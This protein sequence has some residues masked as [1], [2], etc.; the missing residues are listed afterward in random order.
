MMFEHDLSYLHWINLLANIKTIS[1]FQII[2]SNLRSLHCPLLNLIR[3][4]L[5]VGHEVLGKSRHTEDRSFSSMNTQLAWFLLTVCVAV[6]NR[7]KTVLVF[8]YFKTSSC[9]AKRIKTG[10]MDYL[11]KMSNLEKVQLEEIVSFTPEFRVNLQELKSLNGL[12]LFFLL[13]SK[14][15]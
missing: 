13:N 7:I 11:P 9:L 2:T 4:V 12:G 15:Q 6:Q 14:L 10:N 5:G 3:F 1:Y 8:D